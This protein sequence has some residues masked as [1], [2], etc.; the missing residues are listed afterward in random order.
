MCEKGEKCRVH[1]RVELQR[2][3]DTM[4]TVF[5]GVATLEPKIW[6]TFSRVDQD[7]VE[8]DKQVNCRKDDQEEMKKLFATVVLTPILRD[9]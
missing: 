4:Q 9:L 2:L 1:D 8:L 7:L 3:A 6:N 5:S